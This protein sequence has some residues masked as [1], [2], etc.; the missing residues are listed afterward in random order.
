MF[1]S[2]HC[3]KMCVCGV[4]QILVV[5]VCVGVGVIEDNG[6]DDEAVDEDKHVG[7]DDDKS[8]VYMYMYMLM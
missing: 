8:V 2:V 3:Y 1:Q 7:G 5:H 6:D 4:L